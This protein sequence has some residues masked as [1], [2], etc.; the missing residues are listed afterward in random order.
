MGQEEARLKQIFKDMA[1]GTDGVHKLKYDQE[2]KTIIPVKK[3]KDP[4]ESREIIPEDA[5]LG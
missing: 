1:M 2:S 3:D 5:T 4:D